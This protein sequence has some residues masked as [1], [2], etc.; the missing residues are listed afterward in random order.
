MSSKFRDVD[1]GTSYLLPP[2]LD[3]WLPEDHLA[4]AAY[5]SVAFRYIA[6][7]TYPILTIIR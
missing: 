3:E 7:N 4:R 5:D 1:R 2:S 6:A